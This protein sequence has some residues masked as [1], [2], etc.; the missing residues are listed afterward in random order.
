MYRL[1]IICKGSRLL[2]GRM[3]CPLLA[4]LRK[5]TSYA[6]LAAATEY[7]GPSTSIFVGRIGYPRVRVGPMS[8]LEATTAELEVSRYEEPSQWFAQGLS[9][10]EIVE[11]RSATLRSKH[12]EH[13]KS[14]S[15]FAADLTELA[16]A[17][18]PVDVELTFKT[19]PSF[20]LSFSDV[21]RPIGASVTV[22]AMH[23][24]EN[25][26]I[27][28]QVDRIVSDEL[29]AA[30]AAHGLYE[31]GLDV[32]KVAT[33]LSSGALGRHD[34]QKMVPTRWSITATDDIIFKK[35][36]PEIKDYPTVDT[37]YVYESLYMDNHF[38]VLL[39][40]SL[41][42]YENFEAWFP[43]SIWSDTQSPSPAIVAEYEG[44]TGRKRYAANE[45][46]G[47]YA[48]RLAVAEALH[49][50]RRQAGVVVFREIFPQYAVPLGVW[51]VRETARDAMRQRGETF[52]TQQEALAYIDSRLRAQDGRS[53]Q[54]QEYEAHSRILRQKRLS[55]F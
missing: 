19:K 41:F 23:V 17:H 42:E 9:M 31:L 54:L 20:N 27:P 22:E 51:V 4:A 48:A 46:G 28:R 18:R 11:L 2:C 13:I 21:L 14:R 45:G 47:Y 53:L 10:D 3:S 35:L 36:A 30:E 39:I 34:A 12:G 24:A 38:V 49:R 29:K 40:P 26:Q 1:C 55:E 44:F 33:I 32:Y 16:L 37:Y 43:G 52:A 6:D 5:R 50:R 15:K 8:V 7:F 25:P